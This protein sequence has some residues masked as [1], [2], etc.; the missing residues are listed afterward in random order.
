MVK[1]RE[2]WRA[3]RSRRVGHTEWLNY[4]KPVL[5]FFPMGMIKAPTL[6]ECHEDLA[7]Q[8]TAHEAESSPD[9]SVQ[10]RVSGE[11]KSF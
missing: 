6:L 10:G 7:A 4:K 8:D 11:Q 5:F 3:P 2:A 9:T 1:D